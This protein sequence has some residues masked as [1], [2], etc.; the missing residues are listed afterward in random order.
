MQAHDVQ[1]DYYGR[2]LATCSSDRTIKVTLE[3]LHMPAQCPTTVATVDQLCCK[4]PSANSNPMQVFDT[5]GE[6]T[7]ELSQLLGH[8]GPVWQVTWAHPKFGSLLASC[9]LDHKVIVWKETQEAQWVQVGS[10]CMSCGSESGVQ[11]IK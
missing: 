10:A 4:S 2:R 6:Q 3:V 1:F 11:V 9:S 7:V 8:D 5:A